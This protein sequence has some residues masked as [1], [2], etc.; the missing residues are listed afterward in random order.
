MSVSSNFFFSIPLKDE[1]ADIFT[2]PLAKQQFCY[3]R[4]KLNIIGHLK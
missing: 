1:L 3:L 2:K 4:S